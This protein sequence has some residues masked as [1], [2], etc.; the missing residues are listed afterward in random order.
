MRPAW[1]TTR[2]L[3]IAVAIVALVLGGASEAGRLI[4]R[5]SEHRT[6]A[7]FFSRQEV[8]SRVQ[9]AGFD[10][11]MT[12]LGFRGASR[13]LEEPP[14]ELESL[15]KRLLLDRRALVARCEHFAGL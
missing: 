15:C 14:P 2:R 1:L 12:E 8:I 5:S 4:Q 6:R 13:I 10:S 3:M 7:A 9:L 11:M